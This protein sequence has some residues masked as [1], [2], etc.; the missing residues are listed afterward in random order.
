MIRP[1]TACAGLLAI[2]AWVLGTTAAPAEIARI[3]VREAA[4]LLVLLAAL[5]WLTGWAVERSRPGWRDAAGALT[6]WSVFVAG[7]AAL[8]VQREPALAGL[9]EIA[10]DVGWASAPALSVTG[11]GEVAV[12]RRR[13]GSFVIPGEINGRSTTFIFDTGASSLVLTA[14]TA[15]ALGFDLDTLRFRMPVQTANGRAFAA[16]VTIDRLEIGSIT[17]TR[18]PALVSGRGLLHGN[19]LGTSVL[20]RLESYEVRGNRLVLRAGKG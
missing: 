17:L 13:D 1:A 4:W 8:Y 9:R 7:A 12:T 15:Q 3:P 2:A 6:M 14:E 10:A 18:V 20:D 11:T 16:Q 19:L 5:L